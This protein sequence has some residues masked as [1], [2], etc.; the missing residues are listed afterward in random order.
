MDVYTS[1]PSRQWLQN[2]ADNGK[3][4]VD[5]TLILLEYVQ[6]IWLKA[7]NQG[8]L[9]VRYFDDPPPQTERFTYVHKFGEGRGYVEFIHYPA[10]ILPP[11]ELVSTTGAGDTLVGGIVAGLLERESDAGE[12]RDLEMNEAAWVDR[13]LERVGRSLRSRR[14]VG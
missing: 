11:G 13:A 8:L 2:Q 6:E 7:G 5:Q 10:P 3:T 4:I 1:E 12:G 9:H 14:A